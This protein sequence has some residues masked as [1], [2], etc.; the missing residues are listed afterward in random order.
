MIW[1]PTPAIAGFA[2]AA[3]GLQFVICT[4]FKEA[5][6]GHVSDRPVTVDPSL[7]IKAS[8]L[9][10]RDACSGV[11]CGCPVVGAV[12]KLPEL[13]SPPIKLFR[14]TSVARLVPTSVPEPPR[15]FVDELPPEVVR[16][17]AKNASVPPPETPDRG[18]EKTGLV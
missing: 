5:P 10:E 15:R 8:V 11:T 4:P 3:V 18:V 12:G 9:P 2:F 13:V 1:L 14:V 16:I 6:T 17:R 7:L